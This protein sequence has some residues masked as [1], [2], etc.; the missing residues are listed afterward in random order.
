MPAVSAS[1]PG[2]VILFGEHAVVYGQPALAAPVFDVQAKA[3]VNADISAPPGRIL[4]DAPQIELNA[5]LISLPADDPLAAAVRAT[6]VELGIQQPPALKLRVTSTIPVAAGLGSGAAVSVAVI[7]ALSAFLGHPLA[8][9]RVSQLAFEVEKL[10]HGTP[11]GID[12]TVV[13]FGKPVFF[14][15]GQPLE[16]FQVAAPLHLLIGDTGVAS[17]TRIAVGDVRAGWQ[18]EPARYEAL[19]AKVGDLV[20]AARAAI[21]S[22]DLAKL[23][24]L[25]DENHEL[26]QQLGVSSPELDALATAARQAGAKGAK[27]SGGGRGGNMVA[28][29]D[30]T[31]SQ[32]VADALLAAGAKSVIATKLG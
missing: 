30:E 17:P 20:R 1:A 19:F 26:L 32:R 11:S 28:L 21:E 2:K 24:S 5:D 14:V 12:N 29:V 27:L 13:T 8:D 10:H 15:K 7:R 16:T 31:T 22:G 3:I 18:A 6:L 23:G 4:V 25:M 9:E